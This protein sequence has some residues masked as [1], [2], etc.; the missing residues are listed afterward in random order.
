MTMS[1]VVSWFV[2]LVFLVVLLFSIQDIDAILDTKLEM[3]VAQLFADAIGAWGTVV[4]LGLIIICQFCTGATTV[5]VTSRQIYALARDGA[6]PMNNRLHS[7]NSASLPANAVWCTVFLACVV[8]SPFPLSD[9]VFEYIV[10]TTTITIHLAYAIVLGS[11]LLSNSGQGRFSLGRWSKP[12][13]CI[14]F[15][16]AVIAVVAFALPTRWPIRATDV[17]VAGVGLLAIML[18]TL[19]VWIGWGQ[20]HYV[21]PRASNDE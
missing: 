9:H 21:G 16:W 4:F 3:P 12:I 11:R 10:S 2:G 17:N 7:L 14:G 6:T 13:T 5:T 8:V 1:I 15:L 18:T 19:C 20:Y